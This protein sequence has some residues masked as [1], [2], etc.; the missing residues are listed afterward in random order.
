MEKKETGIDI[1]DTRL[2]GGLPG[3]SVVSIVASPMSMGELFLYHDPVRRKRGER[4]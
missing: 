1:L 4:L 2:D 3:G